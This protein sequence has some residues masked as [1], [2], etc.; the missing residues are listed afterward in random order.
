MAKC[1]RKWHRGVFGSATVCVTVKL[2]VRVCGQEGGGQKEDSWWDIIRVGSLVTK[3]PIQTQRLP[4]TQFLLTPQSGFLFLPLQFPSSHSYL[5]SPLNVS[6]SESAFSPPK[7][8]TPPGLCICFSIRGSLDVSDVCTYSHECLLRRRRRR[9]VWPSFLFQLLHRVPLKRHLNRNQCSPF[10][11]NILPL[12]K[13]LTL[14]TF[15]QDNP[16]TQ[17]PPSTTSYQTKGS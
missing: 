3:H 6:F 1:V 13:Q 5:F 14:A 11:Y 9:R 12:F 2:S 4:S 7:T 15:N 17:S 10:P 16:P 8:P